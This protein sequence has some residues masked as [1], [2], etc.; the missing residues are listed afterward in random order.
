MAMWNSA[1]TQDDKDKPC[2]RPYSKTCINKEIQ[3]NMEHIT[4]FLL[5]KVKTSKLQILRRDFETLS[6]K[7]TYF[8]LHPCYWPNKSD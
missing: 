8:L 2:M 4:K 6:M 5:D 3:G 7:D 1:L